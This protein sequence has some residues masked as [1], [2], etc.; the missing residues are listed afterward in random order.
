V[1]IDA[2]TSAGDGRLGA[3]WF[4]NRE[5]P[6]RADLLSRL[7]WQCQTR[8][9]VS[10]Y[11]RLPSSAARRTLG[12]AAKVRSLFHEL[13]SHVMASGLFIDD[14]PGLARA[15]SAQHHP[16]TPW[17]VRAA[18]RAL[19]R[20]SY[21]PEE[22]LALDAFF[23]VEA[24][25]PNLELLLLAEAGAPLRP[26]AIAEVTL[27]PVPARTRAVDSLLGDLPMSTTLT[28]PD[29]RRVG[30]WFTGPRPPRDADLIAATRR[31]QTHGGTVI[32]WAVD[33]PIADLPR[34]KAVAPTVSASRFPVKF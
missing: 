15:A 1:V 30:L 25:R 21:S 31:F 26:C 14:A 34:A 27:V 28:T 18:R 33:D 16:A 4:P 13:G 22:R 32:G 12:D 8:A 23:A 7:A 9:G 20:Q 5:L 17:D 19:S 10:A 3:A 29:S 24:S 11:V 6:V 2:A